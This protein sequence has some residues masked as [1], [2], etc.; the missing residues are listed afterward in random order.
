M[1]SVPLGRV[2]I[3]DHIIA[4][5]PAHEVDVAAIFKPF[6]TASAAQYALDPLLIY[7]LGS[8]ESDW[9]LTLKPPGPAGTG[10]WAPR[11]PAK[12]GYAMPPDGLGWGRGLLQADYQ[13]SFAQT[14]NWRDPAANIDHGCYEL[15]NNIVHFRMLGVANVDPER[16][17]IAAYNCGQGGVTRAIKAG[18]D[19]DHFTTG[20]NYSTDVLHRRARFARLVS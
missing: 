17:G 4:A 19:V 10:D 3:P 20:K 14:G 1:L 18:L 6:V 2:G 7:A 16:A 12:W 13:Q 9:G 11:D 8:R 15:A 5:H